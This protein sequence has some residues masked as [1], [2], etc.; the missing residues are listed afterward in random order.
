MTQQ[1]TAVQ[2]FNNQ[3][4]G[5]VRTIEESGRV[6][7]VAADVAKALGYTN[8]SKA[9]NDHCKGVTKRYIPTSGGTQEMNVIPEGDIYRLAAKSE[10]PNA[11]QFESWVFDEVLPTIRKHGAY[12]T[13]AAIEQTLT[14]PDFI[15]RLATALKDERTARVLAESRLAVA[16]PK[17]E[18]YDT[19]TASPDLMPMDRVAKLLELPGIGRNNLF[20]ALRR[21][22]LLRSNNE[23]Y[24]EFIDRGYFSLKEIKGWTDSDGGYHPSYKTYATQKGLDYI[25]R[26]LTIAIA[27]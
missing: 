20:A 2:I 3:Q 16:E 26:I 11:E 5:E 17:A 19:V 9:I 1:Q 13:P 27:K 18:F 14:D 24:Q 10:L 25:R 22:N 6:L 23:P 4:F 21:L 15:I 8:P 12:L 7:F